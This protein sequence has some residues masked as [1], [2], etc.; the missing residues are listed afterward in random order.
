MAEKKLKK[1][2]KKT[3]AAKDDVEKSAKSVMES[4]NQI[5]LA[6]LGAFAKAQEEGGKIFDTLVKEGLALEGKTRKVSTTRVNEVRGAVEGTVAQV[7]ARANESWDK[8]EQV[9]EERVARALGAL[10]VPTAT[11]VQ[12]LTKRVEELQKTVDDFNRGTSAPKPKAKAAAPKK[13]PVRKKAVR[14][15]AAKKTVRKTA[16]K[17]AD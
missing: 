8:L 10:G 3:T 17:K 13:A 14:K 1:L 6:G 7:Q 16:A 2:S 12:E 5:W 4:A 15:T 9:F 11:D